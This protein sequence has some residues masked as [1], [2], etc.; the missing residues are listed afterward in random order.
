MLRNVR[1]IILHKPSA[2]QSKSK[3]G[4]GRIR[5]IAL[6]NPLGDYGI[7]QYCHELAE[8]LIVNGIRVDVYGSGRS[9]I[10]DF[11]LQRRYGFFPLLGSVVFKEW[12]QF[13]N[14][15]GGA[16]VSPNGRRLPEKATGREPIRVA[17][18]RWFSARFVRTAIERLR[19]YLLPVE[20]ACFLKARGHDVVWTQ[21]PD[22]PGYGVLF[23][24]TCRLLGMPIVHTVHNVLPHDEQARDREVYRQS[25]QLSDVLFVHSAYARQELEHEFPESS[26]KAIIARHGTYTLYP[27]VPA[28][29]LSVR[30][31]LNIPDKYAVI[32]F[33]GGIRPYKNIEAVLAAMAER[34][35]PEA[36]LVVSGEEFEYPDCD[37]QN[38]LRRTYSL[39]EKLGIGDKVRLLPGTL[40]PNQQ[41]ELLEASD[42][43]VLPYLKSYGSG[44]LLLGITFGMH[45]VASRTGGMEEY[46]RS[47]P[48]HTLLK[49]SDSIFVAD[50]LE[51]ALGTISAR[52]DHSSICR[53]ELSWPHIT[54]QMLSELAIRL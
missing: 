50:G 2:N 37:P 45:I 6:L 12:K 18:K 31:Q 13:R 29:R 47:Y 9:I 10:Q 38:P 39:V 34:K 3:S 8:G 48:R 21:W 41:A 52:H 33:C 44:L 20:L 16:A 17:E 54:R 53:P 43:L 26:H 40:H 23:R 5:S 11:G 14:N 27:R 42:I 30:K 49:G 35:W 51:E 4:T 7:A 25:Y 28:A 36:M 19:K 46:L 1:E 22:M 15:G 24:R 32:L